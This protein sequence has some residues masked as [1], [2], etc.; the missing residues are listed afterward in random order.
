MAYQ[1][2]RLLKEKQPDKSDI[3]AADQ[4]DQEQMQGDQG[5]VGGTT[6]QG[7]IT[8]SEAPSV[9]TAT[10]S[11]VTAKP[12]ESVQVGSGGGRRARDVGGTAP[13]SFGQ[14][15]KKTEDYK[16]KIQNEANAFRYVAPNR[17]QIGAQDIKT[18]YGTDDNALEAFGRIR[19]ALNPEQGQKE[20]FRS[21]Q[22]GPFD[23]SLL[24]NEAGI[25]QLLEKDVQGNYT[26]GEKRFDLAMARRDPNFQSAR[27]NLF[28][29]A[30]AAKMETQALEGALGDEKQKYIAD[31]AQKEKERI[32]RLIK[33]QQAEINQQNIDQ[34]EAWKS[35]LTLEAEE[36]LAASESK[37]LLDEYIAA[38][39]LDDPNAAFIRENIGSGLDFVNQN[40]FNEEMAIDAEE[41]YRFNRMNE[42]LGLGEGNLT[43]Y[44]GDVPTDPYSFNAQGY[45]DRLAQLGGEYVPA[46]PPEPEPAPAIPPPLP[47]GEENPPPQQPVDGPISDDNPMRPYTGDPVNDLAGQ[48]R[49]MI[50]EGGEQ[51][52][53]AFNNPSG[54]GAG[55]GRKMIQEAPEQLYNAFNNPSGGGLSILAQAQ[56]TY[57]DN[58]G[59]LSN[60]E[61]NIDPSSQFFKLPTY[62]DVDP[63]KMKQANLSA[64]MG[65]ISR[66]PSYNFP[67]LGSRFY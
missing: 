34:F 55:Q 49:K 42:M 66:A 9:A 8:T 11:G 6:E 67:K 16:Q 12:G 3:F 64:K 61:K 24:Q 36:G 56:D 46:P 7:G 30:Q 54:G 29:E 31:E 40:Q 39:Q 59:E 53:D 51:L 5:G 21:Q 32:E 15:R 20:E 65:E 10:S 63:N 33:G 27:S 22:Q 2:D 14:F 52:Y 17:D 57:G 19:S 45:Q 13:S 60:D 43:A 23:K 62:V 4:T 26:E 41:A 25:G 38:N 44:V 37:R 58:F 47:P 1:F 48:G 50:Q 28:N 18:A 35:G